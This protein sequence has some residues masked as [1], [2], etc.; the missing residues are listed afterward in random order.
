M[1]AWIALRLSARPTSTIHADATLNPGELTH[2][3]MTSAM[4]ALSGIGYLPVVKEDH[5]G[6]TP[7]RLG[8]AERVMQVNFRFQAVRPLPDIHRHSM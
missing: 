4:L 7:D 1:N 3:K 2:N 5:A 8:I 6:R